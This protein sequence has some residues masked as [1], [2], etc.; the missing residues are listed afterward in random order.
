VISEEHLGL[1]GLGMRAGSVVVGTNG[2]RAGLQRDELAMVIVAADC[3]P[4][5]EEKV[6]VL[7]RARGVQTLVGPDARV[8]GGRLGR[9]PVQ[10]VGVRDPKLA[11]GIARMGESA[12]SRRA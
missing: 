1:L 3:S 10:A 8:L 12:E 2:V 9:A 11:A 4:R 6:L 5:T 7:A